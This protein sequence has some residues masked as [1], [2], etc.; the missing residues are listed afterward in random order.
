VIAVHLLVGSPLT[1][2]ISASSSHVCFESFGLAIPLVHNKNCEIFVRACFVGAFSLVH[3]NEVRQLGSN[4]RL[5]MCGNGV[6][7][8][9][10]ILVL[11]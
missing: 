2:D 1:F 9:G 6:I 10:R 11:V 7:Y 8:L 3:K 4:L 5:D